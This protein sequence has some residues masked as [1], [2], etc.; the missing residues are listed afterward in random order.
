MMATAIHTA[1][2]SVT[3]CVNRGIWSVFPLLFDLASGA[4]RPVL[5]RSVVEHNDMMQPVGDVAI[6]K[7]PTVLNRLANRG[8]QF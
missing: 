7:T 5:K 4:N 1:V 3:A 6:G 2:R 8:F